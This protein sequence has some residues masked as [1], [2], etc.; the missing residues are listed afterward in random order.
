MPSIRTKVLDKWHPYFL[1]ELSETICTPLS[2][3]F[4]KSLKEGA[5]ES[6]RKAV[7]TAIYKKGMKSLTENYRPISIT[8]V[9]SKLMESIVRDTIM[10][11]VMKNNLITDNQHGF[12]P[13]RNCKTQLLVCLDDWTSVMES[14]EEFDVIYT[15]FSKAFD[16]V[17]HERLLVKLQNNGIKGNLLQWIRS[18]L[19][20]RPQCV[21]VNGILSDWK[22]VISGVPQGSVIGPILFVIF[23]NDMPDE[24]KESVCKLFADDCKLYR[25]VSSSGLNDLQKELL[26]LENWSTTWQ[27]PFNATKCKVLH[28]GTHNANYSYRLNN[29][30]ST[31]NEKDLGVIIDNELKYHVHAASATKKANQVLGIMKKSYYTRDA[32]TMP[33]LYKS[34]ARPHLEYGNAIWGPFYKKE[35]DMVESV[36][37][38]ATKLI[39]TLKDKPYA[40]RLIALDL[41]S[42]TYRRKRGDMILM[43]KLI[44]GLVRLDFNIFFYTH[45][46]VS[47]QR[48]F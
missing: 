22:D 37:K 47:H 28:F 34:M 30:T 44:N 5:H 16:S 6:W 18:F 32:K 45:A 3:L 7:I 2:I 19:S 26:N 29:H 24:V 12:V 20:G 21:N 14:S 42:M 23:I 9:V 15:D 33:T 39:D 46:Y 11:H 17:A 10:A 48:S 35:I 38:R 1:K 36:Q 25:N 41:P 27:L 4:T 8:S 40:D 31:K 13:G 43:Y